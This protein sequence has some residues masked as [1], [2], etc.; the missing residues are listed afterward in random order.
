MK[1]WYGKQRG[2]IRL[3]LCIG[4]F[5]CVVCSAVK[6]PSGRDAKTQPNQALQGNLSKLQG[7]WRSEDDPASTIEIDGDRFLSYYDGEKMS[8]ET[9]AFI[10]NAEDRNP[11]PDGTYFI[12]KGEFDA[13]IYYLIHVSESRL[14]NSFTG[15]GNTIR[16]T[17]IQQE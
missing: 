8:T 7:T 14:E 12:V 13:M 5:S 4:F 1:Q 16:Y 9:I 15:R 10:D 11:D 3:L 2:V 6:K 17:K